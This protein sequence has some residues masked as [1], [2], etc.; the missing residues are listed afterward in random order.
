[1][2]DILSDQSLYTAPP[3]WVLLADDDPDDIFLF[4]EAF[5]QTESELELKIANDGYEVIDAMQHS[6]SP[7]LIFLDINM[8]RMNGFECIQELS[9]YYDFVPIIF[10]STHQGEDLIKRAKKL[11]ASGYIK[12]PNSF[13]VYK[14]VLSEV[15]KTDWK[16]RPKTDFYLRVEN[17]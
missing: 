15:L 8:P 13:E 11:G 12:K 3:K 6:R 17:D 7:D 14:S 1:M 16:A 10:F 9:A 5:E 2:T 4:Q